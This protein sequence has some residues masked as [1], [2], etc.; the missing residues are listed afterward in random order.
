MIET[1]KAHGTPR[2]PSSLWRKAPKSKY[3]GPVQVFPAVLAGASLVFALIFLIALASDYVTPPP[4]MFGLVV[5]GG[6][7]GVLIQRLLNR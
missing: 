5:A 7:V 3:E 6:F 2:L 1:C 4:V